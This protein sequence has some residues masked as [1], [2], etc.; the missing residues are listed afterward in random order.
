MK[1]EDMC[2]VYRTVI[3]P[4]VEYAAV[5]YHTLIPKYQSLQLE[6]VQKQAMK[7]VYGWNVPY[8]ELVEDGRIETL[9]SRREKA[10]L[11]FALKAESGKF[12]SKWFRK[13]SDINTDVRST[14]RRKYFERQCRTE[15]FRNNPINNMTRV[16]NNFYTNP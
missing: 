15:R 5:I 12:G 8:S 3:R 10:V 9:E 1:P 7:I 14:S 13:R 4:V 6:N 2:K 16:L 11:K